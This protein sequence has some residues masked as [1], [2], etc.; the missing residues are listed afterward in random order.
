MFFAP[1]LSLLI[2]Q[3]ACT[4]PAVHSLAPEVHP[5]PVFNNLEDTRKQGQDCIYTHLKDWPILTKN[6]GRFSS[7]YSAASLHS[8]APEVH[9]PP[10]VRAA[11]HPRLRA[12]VQEVLLQ[13]GACFPGD[14]WN[15]RF[16]GGVGDC[17]LVMRSKSRPHWTQPGTTEG[18]PL[19]GDAMA[20]ITS[21]GWSGCPRTIPRYLLQNG[22]I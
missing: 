17:R 18:Q 19:R 16:A 3:P 14:P 4:V 21:F 7:S 1:I 6:S 10:V 2:Q 15:W 9:P 20:M 5:P 11:L 12:D 13:W 8:L 22:Q